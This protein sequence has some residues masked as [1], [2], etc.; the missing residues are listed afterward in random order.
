MDALTGFDFGVS[1]IVLL[2]VLSPVSTS[3]ERL[4]KR[5]LRKG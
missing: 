5:F 1:S 3:E 4:K 2:P